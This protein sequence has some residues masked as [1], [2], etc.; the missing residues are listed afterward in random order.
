MSESLM[1]P[2][3]RVM[4]GMAMGLTACSPTFDWRSV[5]PAD[6]GVQLLFPCKP[7]TETRSIVLAGQQV[8]MTMVACPAGGRMFAL[9]FA[10]AGNV[11]RVM[12]ALAALRAA[13]ADNFRAPARSTGLVVVAGADP[14]PAAERFQIDGRLPDGSAVQEQ[15]I[16]FAKGARVYQAAVMGPAGGD[17]AAGIF[18]EG[19][20]PAP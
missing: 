13:Q 14:A 4:V 10:D 7:S 9:A 17:E 16:Y 5:R 6:A 20:Q 19:I 12:P 3:R 1:T 8:P 11:E 15:L 18:F 2:V